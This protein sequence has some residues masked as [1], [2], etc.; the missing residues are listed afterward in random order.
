MRV[1]VSAPR[2]LGRTYRSGA[3]KGERSSHVSPVRRV[4]VLVFIAAA[5]KILF[6]LTILSLAPAILIMVTSFTRVIVVLGMLRHALGTQQLPPN[7]VLIGLAL[8]LT[9]FIMTPV[10]TQVNH[11]ALQPYLAH[12]I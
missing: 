6:L 8:F 3:Q 11:D 12:Q 4:F 5:L 9:F 10:W 7:Q 2:A 1:A